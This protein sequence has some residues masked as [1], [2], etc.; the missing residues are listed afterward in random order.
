MNRNLW[1]E[2]IDRLKSEN[3]SWDDVLFV[4]CNDFDISKDNFMETA[5]NTMYDSGY[6]GQYIPKDIKIVG[7]DF[8]LDRGEYDGS[9][10]WNFQQAPARKN[11]E[12]II[13][14][15]TS[16]GYWMT[17]KDHIERYCEDNEIKNVF[18]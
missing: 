11:K 13:P 5:M 2:T 10:W 3:K 16:S 1:E 15:L 9:E 12:Q 4:T 17:L 14:A 18:I 8:W 7:D 6:G